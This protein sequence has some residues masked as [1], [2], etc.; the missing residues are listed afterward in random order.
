MKYLIIIISLILFS[1]TNDKKKSRLYYVS[2]YSIGNNSFER[3]DITV[4]ITK[5]ALLTISI[6]SCHNIQRLELHQYNINKKEYLKHGITVYHMVHTVDETEVATLIIREYYITFFCRDL[7]VDY[8][9]AY[10]YEEL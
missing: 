7:T 9:R 6:P 1:P 5:D 8:R 4:Y 2:H 10:G 3:D